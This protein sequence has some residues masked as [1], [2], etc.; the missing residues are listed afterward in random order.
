MRKRLKQSRLAWERKT[1]LVEA[2]VDWTPLSGV[3][4]PPFYRE[5][6]KRPASSSPAFKTRSP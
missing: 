2:V 5:W 6:S 4:F 1:P 3:R